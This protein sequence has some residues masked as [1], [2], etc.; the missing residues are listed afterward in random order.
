MGFRFV[1]CNKCQTLYV[2]PRPSL[3][4]LNNYYVNAEHI[5]FRNDKIFSQTEKVRQ[6][7]IFAPRAKNV[8]AYVKK[9][10]IHK[11]LAV[12]IGAGYGTFCVELMK[13]NYFNNIIAVEPSRDLANTCST[14]GINTVV[15][16]FEKTNIQNI[17]LIT[18]FELIEH[19]YSPKKLLQKCV[20]S[21]NPKGLLIITTPN[22][23]GFDLKI[24]GKKSNNILAPN[25]INYFNP[26]SLRILLE[27][28]GLRI[29]DIATPGKLDVD[30][31]RQAL[32]SKKTTL[33]YNEYLKFLLQNNEN[34]IALNFQ[35][36]LMKNN[37]SSHMWAVAQKV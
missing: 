10:K 27:N 28:V 21:L 33:K 16:I 13:Y 24:L 20:E 36:F 23:E 25:H 9:A 32:L 15:D 4:M 2:N 11:N 14:R 30:I 6:K 31:V 19:L 17:D 8:M 26:Q 5:K 35:K 22:I 3:K 37:L 29:V 34:K 12:D 18:C 7:Q 1:E